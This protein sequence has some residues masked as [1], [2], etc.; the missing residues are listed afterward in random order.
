LE[1]RAYYFLAPIDD[2]VFA[3][4]EVFPEKENKK[5]V[6]IDYF[7]KKSLSLNEKVDSLNF[8]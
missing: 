8:N 1:D 3:E 7:M 5:E 2:E 6:F 4:L